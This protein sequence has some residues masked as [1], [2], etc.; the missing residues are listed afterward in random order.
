MIVFDLICTED[1]SFEA[2]FGSTEAFEK[3]LNTPMLTCPVCG[4]QKVRKLPAA[5][6]ISKHG[7]GEPAS[8]ESVPVTQN[9]SKDDSHVAAF[10]D[11]REIM[12]ALR[13]LIDGA[14]DVGN[15]F[16]EEARRIHYGE[17]PKR[18]IRGQA[19]KEEAEELRDEGIEVLNLPVPPAE[20]MH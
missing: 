4:T 13:R 7:R 9:P 8:G 16:P 20:D 1:H 19:S 12:S 2:W 10:S 5:I 14:E 11:P 17:A 6:N 18:S 3:Q 15:R